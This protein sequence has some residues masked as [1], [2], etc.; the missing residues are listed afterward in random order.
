LSVTALSLIFNTET[1]ISDYA[2]A[3]GFNGNE[4]PTEITVEIDNSDKRFL[5]PPTFT[6]KFMHHMTFNQRLPIHFNAI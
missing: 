5:L 4:D 1:S 2:S 3:M 6:I